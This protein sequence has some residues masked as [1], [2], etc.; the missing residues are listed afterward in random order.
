MGFR[1]SEELYDVS[2][3]PDCINNLYDKPAYRNIIGKMRKCL[4]K[5]LRDEGDP[6]MFGNGDIFD[7]YPNKCPA[8]DY[9]E[10]V[11]KGEKGI[12]TGWI[13]NSDFETGHD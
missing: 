7:T 13:N 11:E 9:Y 6:R 5:R 2:A 1:P 12:P 3:D 10:R 8:H 4:D